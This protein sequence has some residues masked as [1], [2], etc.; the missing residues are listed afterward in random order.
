MTGRQ[1]RIALWI[2]AAALIAIGLAAMRALLTEISPGAVHVALRATAPERIAFSLLLTAAS[3]ALL[4]L[5]DWLAVRVIGRSL[6]WRTTAAAA[7]TSYTLSHNLGFAILT[8]GSARLRVYRAAGLGLAD[9]ARITVIAS[10]TFWSGVLA[11]TAAA[12]L[13]AR[14]PLVIGPLTLPPSMELP[15]GLLLI[16]VLIVPPVMRLAGVKQLRFRNATI[17]LPSVPLMLAM[18]AIG[19]LDMAS[20]AGALFA[21]MPHA[22]MM[23]FGAFCLAFALGMTI[24]LVTHVPGGVGVFEATILALVPG[25]R[26]GVL[27]ALLLYRVIYYLLP[28]AFAL[29]LIA[30]KPL[31]VLRRAVR[32]AA[33][34]VVSLLV[35]AGGLVLLISGA[36]PAEHPRLVSLRDFL[37]LPFVET[38]H[39][40]ASLAGTA[41]LLTAPALQAR[42]KSGFQLARVLLL[43]GMLF[44][45]LKGVD[46]EEALVLGAVAALLQFSKSAFYRRAGIGAAPVARWWWAAALI[47]LAVSVWAGLLAYQHIPYS[48]DLWWSFTWRGNAPRFLRATLGATIAITAFA[49]WRLVFAPSCPGTPERLPEAVATRALAHA[50]RADAMLAFTGDKRFLIAESEDAFLM[51]EM[52]GRTWVVMGDPVGPSEAW[53]GL[54]WDLR[55]RCDAAHGRLC[56]YQTSVAMLPLL[57]ELGL[58]PIKYGEEALVDLTGGYGLHGARFRSL[59]HSSRKAEAA[60]LSFEIIPA[61]DIPDTLPELRHVSDAWLAGKA[62]GEKGFSLGRFDPAYLRRFDCAV[63]RHAGGSIAAFANIWRTPDRA[64]LSVDLMRHLPDTPYGTMDLLF[65][66][67]MQWGAARGFQRFNLGL[68]PLSGLHG[69]RLAPFWTRLGALLRGRGERF[70]GFQGLRGFKAKYAPDWEPRYIATSPGLSAAH[71][72]MDV[73]ALIG[74]RPPPLEPKA[75]ARDQVPAARIVAAQARETGAPA[76]L[77]LILD[78]DIGRDFRHDLVAQA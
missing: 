12:L 35:F 57:V 52:Q 73:A 10:A 17:P 9:V 71:A 45:L 42:L 24:G 2:A 33:P 13:F 78:A 11:L 49:Y 47:A 66:R 18:A 7:F 14:T 69:Q 62:G 25:D 21:L 51:Y 65:V 5:Y 40:A 15:L 75:H 67:L 70:Y 48:D 22:A 1:Q 3:Y 60:G 41:L 20:A 53:P 58:Q 34:S 59:R 28:L 27:A 72:L 56:F 31:G 63:L 8:G 43:A 54:C 26:A 77:A 46:Y 74:R 76:K 6:P 30:R 16:G 39:F 37:P 68:A 61:A 38:S 23:S 19:A 4:T 44:S 50:R 55:R 29:T 32:I 36:L 64:E